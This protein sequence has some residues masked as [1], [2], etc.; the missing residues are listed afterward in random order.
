MCEADFGLEL[1]IVIEGV[2][3]SEND[4]VKITIKKTENGTAVLTKTFSNITQNTVHLE[5]TEAESELLKVGSYVY[6]LDWY[7]NNAFMCNIIPCSAF[8]VVDKA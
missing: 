1:P 2:T 4:E 5:I 6:S 7:Q 3:F 8:K